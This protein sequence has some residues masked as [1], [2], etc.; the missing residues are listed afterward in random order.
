[1]DGLNLSFLIV[2][3][4][5]L[6][7]YCT[8]LSDIPPLV[9]GCCNLVLKICMIVFF[10]LLILFRLCYIL[11]VSG[12]LLTMMDVYGGTTSDMKCCREH[13]LLNSD[14]HEMGQIKLPVSMVH[15]LDRVASRRIQSTQYKKAGETELSV[16]FCAKLAHRTVIFLLVFTLS[17]FPSSYLSSLSM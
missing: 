16:E 11:V 12:C 17:A 4:V 9:S 15:G 8:V 14:I 7:L 10:F 6:F 1:M 2:C 5:D 13:E 3:D